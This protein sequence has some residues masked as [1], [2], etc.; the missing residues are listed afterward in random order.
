[1]DTVL[2]RPWAIHAND[3]RPVVILPTF[4]NGRWLPQ[5]LNGVGGTGLSM[6]VVNDGSTD[7]TPGLLA[8][9][10]RSRTGSVQVLTHASNCGKAAALRTGFEAAAKAGFTHALTIDTDG[11]HEPADLPRLWALATQC[12][13]T[14]VI[15][16]RGRQAVVPLRSRFG[17]RLSDV[18]LHLET[19]WPTA[20]S[21]CGL[22]V[23]P[24]DLVARVRCR[25]S[26]FG[27]E[28]EIIART[29][30]AGCPIIEA[31]VT[32]HYFDD[33]RAV[34]HFRPLV[35]SARILGLHVFLL[36]GAMRWRVGGKIREMARGACRR[37]S[38]WISP[39]EMMRL[40]RRDRAG[41]RQA[42]QGIAVG[43]FVANLPV[44]G[45]Q[46]VLAAALARLLRIHP[47]PA[48]LAA[49]ISTPPVNG[50]L[51]GSAILLGH[52]L[53]RGQWLPWAETRVADQGWST[54][55]AN[56]LL[57]WSVGAI[58]L[59][60]VMGAAAFLL[61]DTAFRWVPRRER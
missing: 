26:R 41:Q 4:N 39:A 20:D 61:A 25:A 24:L 13:G 42:A 6:I 40:I 44:Y 2:S 56:S 29:R 16:V 47:L 33:E 10:A 57:D 46:T 27:Y 60:L 58:A 54:V 32:S 37:F 59:G 35:D 17:R 14:L 22:R 30:W 15:G 36:A 52:R 8:Q 19:G 43:V 21:Q 48:V 28:T 9:W 1:M 18:L 7:D 38:Q 11:Q 50:V 53:L 31:P 49:Q 55:A 5:V 23:Y 51:I 3:W 12:P 34:S 45:A